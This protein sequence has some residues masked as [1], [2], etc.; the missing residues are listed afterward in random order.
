MSRRAGSPLGELGAE[1]GERRAICV[2]TRPDDHVPRRLPRLQIAAPDFTQAPPQ[3]IAGHRGGLELWN[4]QSHARL[5]RCVVHPDHV[6][7]T[8]PPPLS[9]LQDSPVFRGRSQPP[10]AR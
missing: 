5:A 10:G 2:T 7:V 8:E 6:D 4:D 1:K 3:T 9:L